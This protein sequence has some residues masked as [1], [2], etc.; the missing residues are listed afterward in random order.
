VETAVV[1]LVELLTQ[2][3]Q[4]VLQIQVAVAALVGLEIVLLEQVVLAVRVLLLL[5]MLVL[6]VVLA[7]L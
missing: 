4:M 2:T 1:V 5:A 7:E 3:A 6:S